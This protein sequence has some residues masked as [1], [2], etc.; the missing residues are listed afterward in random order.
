MSRARES[1]FLLVGAAGALLVL[2][3]AAVLAMRFG[4]SY[5]CPFKFLFGLPCP[6]CGTTR[7]LAALAVLDLPASLRFNPLVIVGTAVALA[8]YMFANRW[9]WLRRTGWPLFLGALL[10]NWIYLLLY[11][12]R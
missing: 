6:T 9:P 5:P 12:P 4:L 3:W 2:A 7:S 8:G 1:L 10:L 11:L